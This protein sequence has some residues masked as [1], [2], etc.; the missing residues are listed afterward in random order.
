MFYKI[1]HAYSNAIMC[2]PYHFPQTPP[3]SPPPPY[4]FLLRVSASYFF[5][6]NVKRYC[7]WQSKIFFDCFQL[8][9]IICQCGICQNV[10]KLYCHS[11]GRVRFVDY[12]RPIEGVEVGHIPTRKSHIFF[13]IY[14]IPIE[15][16]R[17][18]R[19]AL[20]HTDYHNILSILSDTR[21]NA[22]SAFMREIIAILSIRTSTQL[23]SACF[24]LAHV[25]FCSTFLLPSRTYKEGK[26]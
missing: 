15:R 16:H 9:R 7:E 21:T 18:S 3:H 2:Q 14:W 6:V 22:P 12:W 5:C 1:A 4:S 26:Q 24:E 20:S 11:F 19:P 8:F 17:F 13:L 25:Y 23:P 10:R